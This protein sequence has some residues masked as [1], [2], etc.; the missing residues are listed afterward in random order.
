MVLLF[1]YS[2]IIVVVIVVSKK[3]F[4]V[5]VTLEKIIWVKLSRRKSNCV[6]SL[7]KQ[8]LCFVKFLGKMLE[9]H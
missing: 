1:S 2:L 9:M 8:N 7:K 4:T 5:L 6:W 3:F